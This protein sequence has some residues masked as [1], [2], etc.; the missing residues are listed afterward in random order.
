M[1]D[2]S[3]IWALRNAKLLFGDQVYSFEIKCI[4]RGATKKDELTGFLSDVVIEELLEELCMAT[5]EV[6]KSKALQ[7]EVKEL[8]AENE[9][10]KSD[11]KSLKAENETL[12]TE[13]RE[14]EDLLYSTLA[15]N[16]LLMDII[17]SN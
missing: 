9:R 1:I 8:K 4:S 6:S 10:L 17:R 13:L 12:S 3:N 14:T 5:N 11:V 2:L 16:L 7:D 15:D